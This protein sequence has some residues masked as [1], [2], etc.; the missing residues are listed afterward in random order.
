VI[1]H[2]VGFVG[3]VAKSLLRQTGRL[4]PYQNGCER[5]AEIIGQFPTNAETLGGQGGEF[6]LLDFTKD[7]NILI[8]SHQAISF[9]AHISC[10]TGY[11]IF[12]ARSFST[13]LTA[14]SSGESPVTNS[15]F[16]SCT[17]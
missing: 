6:S 8:I 11:R 15:Q 12:A 4:L 2:H 5:L 10:S 14:I 9:S 3:A 13:R 16:A 17:S 7:A 1:L